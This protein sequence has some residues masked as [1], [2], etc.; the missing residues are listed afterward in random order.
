MDGQHIVPTMSDAEQSSTHDNFSGLAGV[1]DRARPG[2]PAGAI[3][4][5]LEGLGTHPRVADI[6]CGTGIATRQL[7]GA[8]ARVTGIDPNG[9]MLI[10][11]QSNVP[12]AVFHAAPAEAT[13]LDDGAF[14][15]VTC[16]QSF[17]WFDAGVAFSE[18]AR[19]LRPRGRLALVW[20]VR[21]PDHDAMT[22]GYQET[23]ERAQA[24]A[25]ARGVPVRPDRAFRAGSLPGF[26]ARRTLTFDNP[27]V[28]DRDGLLTR[29]ASAS[30]FPRS[31]PLR[32]ELVARLA[33][34]YEDHARDGQVTI[35]QRTE[36]TLGER[37]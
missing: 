22:A 20:N 23:V 7:A 6:G 3:A 30:Y 26:E 34:L 13:G 32:T 11:A 16:F 15:I 25:A 5:I 19:M 4:A 9:D 2:Y 36:V 14:D 21:D 10:T 12:S 31:G 8:G 29:A 1:Y 18:F 35:A 17:H 37:S 33:A 28:L 24:D 27:Q